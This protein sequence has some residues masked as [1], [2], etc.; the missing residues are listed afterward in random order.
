MGGGRPGLARA[1]KVLKLK[2]GRGVPVEPRKDR[3]A[4]VGVLV[5]LLL[6]LLLLTRVL[7]AQ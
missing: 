4:A 5:L 3:V 6:L 2:P 7:K 1:P